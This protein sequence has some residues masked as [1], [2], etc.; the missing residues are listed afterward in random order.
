MDATNVLW[1]ER[2]ALRGG[3]GTPYMS[4]DRGLDM[5]RETGA[6]MKTKCKETSLDLPDEH[7]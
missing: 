1:L 2:M 4:H 7:R 3:D 5:M 6:D